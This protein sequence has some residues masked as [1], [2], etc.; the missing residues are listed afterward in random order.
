MIF[1]IVFLLVSEVMLPNTYS[2]SI[3]EDKF[4][5][6]SSKRSTKPMEKN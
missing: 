5:R 2:H 6:E 3:L 1:K 4:I